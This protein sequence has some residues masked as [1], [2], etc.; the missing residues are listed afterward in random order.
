MS[1]FEYSALDAAGREKRGVIEADTERH[2]RTLLRERGLAPLAVESIRAAAEQP[3]LRERFSPPGLSRKGLALLTR[4][5]STLVRAGLTIEECLNVLIEQADSAGARRLLAGVRARVL[6]GQSL[7]RGLAAF[8]SAFPQIYRAMIEAGEHSGKL[9]DVLERLADYTESRE[10]LRDTIL[11]AFIYPALVMILAFVIVTFLLVY[12]MPQMTRVFSSVGQT[13]PLA[14]R[15]L[16]AMSDFVRSYGLLTLAG[17]AAVVVA[18]WLAL[19][20]QG[21]RTRWHAWLLRVPVVGRLTR[22]VN[23]ARFADTL[24][25]LTTAGVPLLASLQS[26]A[27]VLTNLPMKGAVEEAVRR[28]REGAALAPA[29]G[30]AKLFPPLVIHLIASGEA[31]G[32]LDTMLARAAEAQSRELANW[33]RGLT[34]LLEPLLILTMGG[35]V[36]FVVVAIL[37]PIFE[38]NTLVR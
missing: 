8:P 10:G 33:V 28:V 6:E 1:G 27:A 30:A 24:G 38:M 21:L 17:V 14:T 36:L 32:R 2:A 29:L 31:T 22:G 34:A 19:R 13:L 3:G 23:A 20:D 11:I 26:A 25:I 15:I 35:V 5:F 9:G 18:A 12:I 7:S 4:Q 16:I 37:L